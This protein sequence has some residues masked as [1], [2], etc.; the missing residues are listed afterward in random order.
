MEMRRR[1]VALIRTIR[2]LSYHYRRIFTN[3]LLTARYV[4][5]Y[6]FIRL[7][8]QTLGLARKSAMACSRG[9]FSTH[10][11]TTS[12]SFRSFSAVPEWAIRAFDPPST[13][14]LPEPTPPRHH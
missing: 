3:C 1:L 4:A 6:P 11:L 10:L 12:A 2:G 8:K 7:H 9:L 14:Q 13:T 5:L